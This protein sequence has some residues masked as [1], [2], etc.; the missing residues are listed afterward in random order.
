MSQMTKNKYVDFDVA[1][2]M[3]MSEQIDDGSRNKLTINLGRN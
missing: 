2:N 1:L 3:N